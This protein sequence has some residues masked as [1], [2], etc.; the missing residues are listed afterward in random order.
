LDDRQLIDDT[1]HEGET[2]RGGKNTRAQV[3]N[4]VSYE[5]GSGDLGVN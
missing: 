3:L 4:L 2:K 1:H 5:G